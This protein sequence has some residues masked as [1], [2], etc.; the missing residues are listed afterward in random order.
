MLIWYI[1]CCLEYLMLMRLY[2]VGFLYIWYILS[3]YFTFIWY[4]LRPFGIGIFHRFWL[5]ISRQSGSPGCYSASND[6]SIA[7]GTTRR[8]RDSADVDE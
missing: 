4:I 6:V 3:E 8:S 7:T 2:F 1:W 5:V